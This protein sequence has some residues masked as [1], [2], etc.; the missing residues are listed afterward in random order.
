MAACQD[1]LSFSRL[2]L[3]QRRQ[4]HRLQLDDQ[5]LSDNLNQQ[6]KAALQAN[7]QLLSLYLVS[8]PSALAGDDAA[9]AQRTDLGSNEQDRFAAYW[10]QRD[11]N[12]STL[13]VTEAMIADPTLK[14][15]GSPFKARYN[16]PKQSLKPCLLDP[17]FD[18]AA[19]QKNLITTLTF[20]VIED[21]RQL[22]VLGMDIS[23]SNLQQLAS[24]GS[25]GL[26]QDQSTISI[27]SPAG[28]LAGYSEDAGQLGQGLAKVYPGEATALLDL[29]R[30]SQAHAQHS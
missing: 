13:A 30:Q 29:Q 27:L 17:Y 9:F 12:L 23:L 11:G 28:L 8:E 2:V 21:G 22:A 6:I 16:C 5:V 4:A 3:Q 24:S 19:G 10:A 18:D 25:Q 14:R 7:P 1:G 26:Y 15:D 20:P